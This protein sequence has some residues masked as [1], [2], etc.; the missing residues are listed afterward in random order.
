M[1]VFLYKYDKKAKKFGII[2]REFNYPVRMCIICKARLPK[3][4]LFRYQVK[5]GKIMSFSGSGRSFYFCEHCLQK[6]DKKIQK[7]LNA[8]K[9]TQIEQ[10]WGKKLKEIATK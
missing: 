6:N 7:I 3:T 5:E 4:S 2:M 8:K 1:K 9:C 10:N